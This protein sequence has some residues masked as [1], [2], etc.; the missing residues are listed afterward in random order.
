MTLKAEAEIAKLQAETAA[1]QF[2]MSREAT[3]AAQADGRA[4]LRYEG[5]E[6]ALAKAKEDLRK[7]AGE[8]S[9]G[10]LIF[11]RAQREE[12][13]TL[14]DWKFQHTYN[15]VG[16]VA[17]S[18][19]QT[20]IDRLNSWTV[21]DPGC[22]ITIIF[23]S[24]GGSVI[25]G[26]A[27]FDFIRFIRGMGHKVTIIA[28]GYAASMAGILLQAGDVRVMAKG[29][30]LLIHEVAFATSGKIG[31]IEDMYKF[32]ERLKEQA[33]DIF[34]ERSGGKL[35]REILAH[36]WT[37][38]DWWLSPAEALDLGLVDEIR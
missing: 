30:W 36:N 4:G 7:A 38:K 12:R 10:E 21:T 16:Q 14:S 1:I 13:A 9:Y 2:R 33:A 32:G 18:T 35:T 22:D 5:M 26:M 3:L 27:L 19:V 28:L 24:P 29:S 31:E 23:N 20:C 11:H 17:S 25:D 37:R 8:A 34:I 6:I 15:F